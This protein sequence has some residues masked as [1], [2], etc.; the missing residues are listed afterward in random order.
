MA[1]IIKVYA[2]KDISERITSG[3][4]QLG[5]PLGKKVTDLLE[6]V[7]EDY[8]FVATTVI[9]IIGADLLVE[10]NASNIGLDYFALS[11]IADEIGEFVLAYFGPCTKLTC[12]VKLSCISDDYEVRN[13]A[14]L[15]SGMN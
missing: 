3:V 15:A 14:S 2:R 4:S 7:G 8:V 12:Q 10:V 11:N 13:Q 5:A 9:D 6:G 1:T